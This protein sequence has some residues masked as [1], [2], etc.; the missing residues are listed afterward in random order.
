M[1]YVDFMAYEWLDKVNSLAPEELAKVDNLKKFVF[2]VEALP[3]IAKYLKT[4]PKVP[5]NGPMAKWGGK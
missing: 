5:F 4:A 2:R 3:Q 1:T